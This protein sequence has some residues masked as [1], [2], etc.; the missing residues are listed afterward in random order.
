[1]NNKRL[2]FTEGKSERYIPI[3]DIILVQSEDNY[4]DFILKNSV[5][6]RNVRT[7]LS[8]VDKM[9]AEQ[10][11]Y[12]DHNLISVSRSVIINTKYITKIVGHGRKPKPKLPQITITKDNGEEVV[13][14][15]SKPRFAVLLNMLDKTRREVLLKSAGLKYQLAIP[16]NELNREHPYHNGHEYVDLGLPSG[17]MWA[18][19]N[20][21]AEESDQSGNTFEFFC[22][23]SVIA[24][25][26]CEYSGIE[27]KSPIHNVALS[28]LSNTQSTPLVMLGDIVAD[29]IESHDIAYNQW[30]GKWLI[31]TTEDF[32]ELKKNCKMSWCIVNGNSGALVT[33]TNGNSIFLPV[34]KNKSI[35][36]YWTIDNDREWVYL[37]DCFEMQQEY[38]EITEETN[39]PGKSEL[40][41]SEI[42]SHSELLVRPI[43]YTA[44]EPSNEEN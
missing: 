1:M 43:F 39:T 17:T 24:E 35:A 23:D 9:I 13:M 18:A 11:T 15:A 26:W 20:I 29:Y 32:N 12:A 30:G 14:Q 27:E 42:S 7:T 25:E 40:K 38:I 5:I 31:P 10:G 8:N 37:F 41:V 28:N 36:Q 34:A 2:H 16:L 3:D 33:G 22:K 44:K 6:E 21:G 4:C 19:N